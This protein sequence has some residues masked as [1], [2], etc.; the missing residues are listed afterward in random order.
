MTLSIERERIPSL[1]DI[2]EIAKGV[3]E[4]IDREH[5]DHDEQAR[6]DAEP[7]GARDEAAGIG[8]IQAQVGVS[9]STPRAGND[10][11]ASARI[12]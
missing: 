9:A 4:E 2:E 3:A 7:P 12:A 8:G 10:G 6:E 5:G 1:A 11:V